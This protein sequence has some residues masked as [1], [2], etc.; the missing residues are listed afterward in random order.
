MR[1]FRS[2]TEGG[3]P[4]AEVQPVTL[5]PIGV[6]RNRIRA[7]RPDGW[8][9]T[10]SRIELVDSLAPA[11]LGGLDGFSHIFVLFWMDQAAGGEPRPLTLQVG[12]DPAARGILATRSQLRPNPLGCSVVRLLDIKGASLG[13][14]GLD[15]I[16]RTPVLDIKPYIPHFDS[17]ADARV[18][19]WIYDGH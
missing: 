5:M 13:V 12:G 15:A 17:V 7:P 19:A 9:S 16:D 8:D 11:V 6:V 14:R 1:L 18:P 2:L 3:A 10:E 4:P